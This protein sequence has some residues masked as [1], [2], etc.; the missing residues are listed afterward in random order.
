MNNIIKEYLYNIDIN[1]EIFDSLKDDYLDFE[2]W[3]YKKAINGYQAYITYKDN[4]KLG[5]ILILKIEDETEDFS[6]FNK[7]LDKRKRLKISTLKV[8]DNGKNI[9]KQYLDIVKQK[10]IKNNIDEIYA[11]IYKSKKQLI[12][13]LLEFGFKI[14]TTKESLKKDSTTELEYVM[15]KK[16]NKK[17]NNKIKIK[18]L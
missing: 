1:D 18:K 3:Y 10:A 4:N 2:K 16:E 12:E 14:Y 17:E 8:S 13:L 6:T 15:I 7:P 5:S 11:T 9:G